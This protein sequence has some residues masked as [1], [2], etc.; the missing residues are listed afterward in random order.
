MDR[1]LLL[2]ACPC[3]MNRWLLLKAGPCL[4]H[5]WL[6]LKAGPCLMNRWL[7]PKAHLSHLQSWRYHLRY[8]M[9]RFLQARFCNGPVWEKQRNA[10]LFWDFKQHCLVTGSQL[11]EGTYCFQPW[12]SEY[13][14]RISTLQDET[15]TLSQNIRNDPVPW[16]HMLSQ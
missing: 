13:W 8:H 6:L 7:L 5:R 2:K 1:W 12:Q 16:H 4:M 3:L 9:W 15:T 10:V 14:R 11:S